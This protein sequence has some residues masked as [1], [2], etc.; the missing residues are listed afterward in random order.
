MLPM[1][2]IKN[3]FLE[4]PVPQHLQR[5][6]SLNTLATQYWDLSAIPRPR[7]FELLGINCTNELEKEKLIEFTTAEGQQDLFTY[8][9]RPRRT[10]LE[11]LN[12]FPHST[13]QLTLPILFELLD[14]IKPR[15]FSIASS[16]LSGKLEILVAIVEYKTNL[17]APRMGLCSNWLNKITNGQKI[18]IVIKKGTLRWPKNDEPIVMV[19]PGT[20]LAPFRSLLQ[21]KQATWNKKDLLTLFFGCRNDKGDFHCK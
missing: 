19:G 9:N 14:P 16:P 1:L 13:A 21:H 7:A 18:R 2:Y 17:K 20:G 8:A 12:D 15:S 3:F 5:P 6:L 11:V 4:M 10:I